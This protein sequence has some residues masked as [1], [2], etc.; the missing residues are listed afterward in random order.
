[1]LEIKPIQ[2]KDE[3][4]QVCADCGAEYRPEAMAY[5][6]REDGV[7][8]GV[9]QFRITGEQ[10]EVYGLTNASGVDDIEALILM[11]R[12]ALNFVD[13]CG[14]HRAVWAS[15]QAGVSKALGF[16][17]GYLDLAGYFDG[18]CGGHKG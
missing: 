4:R 8:L 17:E 14:V 5:G 15:D 12:A 18:K 2:T 6:A 7:L 10:A 3:Q 11:G 16:R 9:C 13:L 1:M